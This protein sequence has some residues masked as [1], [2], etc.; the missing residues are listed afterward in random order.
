VKCVK[1][2]EKRKKEKPERKKRR[3]TFVCEFMREKAVPV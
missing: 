2:K 1:K 3:E